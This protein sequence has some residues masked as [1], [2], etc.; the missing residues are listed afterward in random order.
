MSPRIRGL[1]VLA[2]VGVIVGC[3]ASASVG[4]ANRTPDEAP[5]GCGK[6]S[7]ISCSEGTGWSCGAGDNPENQQSN[8]SCSIP[9]PD[10]PNDD[11]CCF[12]WTYGSTCTPDDALT[13]VCQPGSYGYRCQAGDN[14]ASLDS[15]LNC[16]SPTPDG[17]DDD[18]CCQ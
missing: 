9:T 6:D 16:S 14:P 5:A 13:S 7:S 2:C 17:S 8:L 1:A 10:G 15:S 18:F 3:T 11:F 4:P 12:E